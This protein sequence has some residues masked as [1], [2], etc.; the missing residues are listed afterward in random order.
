MTLTPHELAVSQLEPG[1]TVP[2]ELIKS[3]RFIKNNIIGN[4]TKK[5]LYIQ[6]GIVKRKG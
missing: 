3:L 6:L 5:D 1:Q 2:L 4:K